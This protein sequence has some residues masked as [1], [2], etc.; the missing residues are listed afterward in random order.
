[1]NQQQRYLPWPG[2]QESIVQ[3]NNRIIQ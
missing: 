1:M 2:C 3:H